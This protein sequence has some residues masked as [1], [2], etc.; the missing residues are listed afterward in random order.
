MTIDIYSSKKKG[1]YTSSHEK[2]P[3][4]ELKEC[5]AILSEEKIETTSE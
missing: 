3:S 1:T 4:Q 2:S 5:L